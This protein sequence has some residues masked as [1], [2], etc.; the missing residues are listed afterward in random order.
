LKKSSIHNN[1]PTIYIKDLRVINNRDLSNVLLVD[2][3]TYS[4]GFQL[5]NGIPIIPFYSE[6]EDQELVHLA[7]YALSLCSNDQIPGDVRD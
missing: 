6:A 5:A 7:S 4:F 2:N 3:S 1:G